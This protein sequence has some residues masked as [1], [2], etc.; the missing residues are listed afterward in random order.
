V[1]IVTREFRGTDQVLSFFIFSVVF[2]LKYPYPYLHNER[3]DDD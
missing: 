3:N 1:Q 2:C